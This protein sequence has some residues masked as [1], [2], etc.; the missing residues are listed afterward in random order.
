MESRGSV[1]APWLGR[2][3]AMVK[4]GQT[5]FGGAFKGNGCSICIFSGLFFGG[6]PRNMILEDDFAG[7]CCG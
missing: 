6:C 3:K 5:Y 4:F 1:A 7:Y 2:E